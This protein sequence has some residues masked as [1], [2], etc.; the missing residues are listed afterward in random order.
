AR[1]TGGNVS[2]PLA[3]EG[4][5]GGCPCI[6][7]ASEASTTSPTSRA[8]HPPPL[9][10]PRKGEGD[11]TDRPAHDTHPAVTRQTSM[12]RDHTHVTRFGELVWTLGAGLSPQ[13]VGPQGPILSLHQVL[14]A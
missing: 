5:G 8:Y 11:L 2:S 12:V 1:R 13:G 4:Q 6:E 3:G 14:N 9:S 7:T 10:P